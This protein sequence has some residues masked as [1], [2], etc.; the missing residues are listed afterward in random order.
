METNGVISPAE[1]SAALAS[2]ERSR[3]RVAWTGYPT[4]YWLVMA[5]GFAALQFMV[6]LPDLLSL[7][8][9][10]VVTAGLVGVAL[11]SGRVRGVCEGWTRSAMRLRD[12]L[13]L[14]GP[15]FVVLFAG[16]LASR[17]IWWSTIPA[18]VLVF[19]LFAGTGLMLS[20]RG[21]RR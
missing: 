5:A 20:A 10:A 3:T 19:A 2:V 6:L 1:A 14:F 13:L 17:F 7:V 12:G 9:I 16:A 15:T 21:G 8:G 11:V 18:G 4:W